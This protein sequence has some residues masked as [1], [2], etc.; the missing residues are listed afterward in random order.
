MC[1]RLCAAMHLLR[2]GIFGHGVASGCCGEGSCSSGGGR[3]FL[4][5]S[6]KRLGRRSADAEFAA[7]VPK[8]LIYTNKI[9]E[10]NNKKMSDFTDPNNPVNIILPLWLDHF[11]D[12]LQQMLQARLTAE[13]KAVLS[14]CTTYQRIVMIL[15]SANLLLL[16]LHCLR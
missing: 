3:G 4:I 16:H 15:S 14:S 5:L 13:L 10:D 1:E 12:D 6:T 2:V 11:P 8:S 9:S 7:G